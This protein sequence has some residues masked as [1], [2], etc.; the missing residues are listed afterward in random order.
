MLEGA[1]L[2]MRSSENKEHYKKR[3]CVPCTQHLKSK[4]L[5]KYKI[6]ETVPCDKQQQQKKN[7][8]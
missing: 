3:L 7:V 6:C 2:V 4:D 1:F 8:R 5:E